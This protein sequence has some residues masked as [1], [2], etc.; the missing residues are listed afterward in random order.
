MLWLSGM[1][2]EPI[3]M[4][5][6][7]NVSMGGIHCNIKC[8]FLRALNLLCGL[9]MSSQLLHSAKA[10]IELHEQTLESMQSRMAAL[11]SSKA[12]RAAADALTLT[13]QVQLQQCAQSLFIDVAVKG[14][15]AV[16]VSDIASAHV[17]RLP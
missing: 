9:Q 6:Y 13:E 8:V 1:M 17:L 12:Q 2:M 4:T 11:D 10:A 16:Y 3:K 14:Q 15:I 5:I 7:C